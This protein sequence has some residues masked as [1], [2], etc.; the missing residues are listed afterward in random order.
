MAHVE[1]RKRFGGYAGEACT[2]L[3]ELGKRWRLQR[4]EA[5]RGNGL[6]VG[7]CQGSGDRGCGAPAAVVLQTVC[8]SEGVLPRYC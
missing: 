6:V 7:C 2:V 5:I 3:L 4:S 8:A 1:G